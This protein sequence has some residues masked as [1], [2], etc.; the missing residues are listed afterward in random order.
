MNFLLTNPKIDEIP[1]GL[2][3]WVEPGGITPLA[4]L[5]F[6]RKW[7]AYPPCDDVYSYLQRMGF[8]EIFRLD[9]LFSIVE[10]DANGR[11]IPAAWVKTNDDIEPV[12]SSVKSILQRSQLGNGVRWAVAWSINELLGNVLIHA[13]ASY[14]GLV[15]AQVFPSRVFSAVDDFSQSA[16]TPQLFVTQIPEGQWTSIMAEQDESTPKQRPDGPFRDFDEW[17]GFTT[18]RG[19]ASAPVA[20][21]V[22][23]RA[24]SPTSR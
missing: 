9:N 16:A 8:T 3:K 7:K 13:Q 2:L 22:S 20:V 19:G 24:P 10:H 11:F 21:A 5:S 12:I 6:E 1:L 18:P 17:V 4:A 14:G 23:A 15:F